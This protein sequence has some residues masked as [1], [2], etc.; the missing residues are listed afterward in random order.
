MLELDDE[1]VAAPMMFTPFTVML[2]TA[3]LLL[4]EN[5]IVA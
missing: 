5:E 1:A 4:P 3:V 2:S